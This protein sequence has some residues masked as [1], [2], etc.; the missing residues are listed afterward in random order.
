MILVW[1]FPPFWGLQ[2][3]FAPCSCSWKVDIWNRIEYNLLAV[4]LLLTC[5]T[6]ALVAHDLHF[7]RSKFTAS[8]LILTCRMDKLGIWFLGKI[9]TKKKLLLL[10][11]C[12]VQF[13][14]WVILSV[15]FFLI[16]IYTFHRWNH[17]VPLG[18]IQFKGGHD[19]MPTAHKGASFMELNKFLLFWG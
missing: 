4:A 7:A 5:L 13:S 6:T 11:A 8:C 16:R 15:W 9:C 2:V 10:F 14:A 3:H 12:S 18:K 1:K 19:G 17:V